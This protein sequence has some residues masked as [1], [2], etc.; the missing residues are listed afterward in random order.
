M[1]IKEKLRAFMD[2]RANRMRREGGR[3][4]PLPSSARNALTVVVGEF[5]GTFMFLLLAFTGAQTALDTNSPGDPS[6]PL[7]PFSL[8]YIAAS[9]G[10][11]LAVNVWIFFRVTGGMFNPAVTLGLALVGAVKPLRALMVFVTQLVAAIAAAAVVDGLL[12]GPLGVTNKLSNGTNIPQGLFLEMFLTSQLVLTVFFLAVEKH[13]ATFL[14][15][16]GIG[17]SVFVAHIAGTDY[18]GTGINP[19]RSFGPAVLSGFVGYHW[20]YWLGPFMGSVLAFVVYTLLKWLDYGT[21]NPGQDADDV[22]RADVA[23]LE[24]TAPMHGKRPAVPSDA[25]TGT[26][27]QF[28]LREPSMSGTRKGSVGDHPVTPGGGSKNG[29]I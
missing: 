7:L 8:L 3:D 27:D 17:I 24:R 25:G 23:A 12:P 18:T 16:V 22:E 19:A 1:A 9:F 29:A 20:I 21:A 15:P 28:T 5:C 6:A 14:A 4:H 2:V 26:S 11:A 13:R 10:T